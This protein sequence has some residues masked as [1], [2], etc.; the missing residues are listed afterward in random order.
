MGQLSE[1]LAHLTN[2]KMEQDG[3]TIS[4]QRLTTTLTLTAFDGRKLFRQ[5]DGQGR[6]RIVWSDR[7]FFIKVADLVFGGSE[8]VPKEGDQITV[9]GEK[10]IVSGMGADPCYMMSGNLDDLYRIHT[11]RVR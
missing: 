5:I 2:V 7:D 4:Y 1:A 9:N 11:K 8:S 10:Y 6:T 3:F